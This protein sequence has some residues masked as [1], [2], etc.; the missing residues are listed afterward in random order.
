M[1]PNQSDAPQ[2]VYE[3][4][5][6]RFNEITNQYSQ[7]PMGWIMQAYDRASNNPWIQNRRVKQISSLP[8]EYSKDDVADAIRSPGEHELM[9]RQTHHALEATAYPMLKIRKVYTDIMTYR[10]YTSPHYITETDAK[11][12]MFQREM[13]LLDKFNQEMDPKATAHKMAGQALQEGK[14]FYAIRYSVDKAHNKVNYVFPQQL[15]SNWVKI[16]GFNNISGYTVS[17]NMFYFLQP[18]TDWRQYGDLLEPY[19]G[20]FKNV[21]EKVPS[22]VVYASHGSYRINLERFN[23]LKKNAQ[24]GLAGNPDPYMQNGRWAYWVT[25]PV[26]R[27]FVFEIDDTNPFA[28]SP[29]TGLYLSMQAIAQYEQVQLE[30]VQ[31]PLVSVM[32]GE[33]PYSNDNTSQQKDLYK[34]SNGGR[35]LFE[36]LWYQML[37]QNNTSGIGLYLAPAANLKLHQ[38]TEAPSATE[39]S[40]NGYAYT[41]EK[42]GLAGLIPISDNPRAGTVNISI[43]IE[44]RYCL[45]IYQQ[46]EKMMNYLYSRLNL[47]YEW[48]FHMFG[49]IYNDEKMR[50]EMQKS[51][52]LGL[53]PDLYVYNALMD[54]SLLDDMSMSAAVKASGIL[55]K[56]MPL[57]SSYTA[58]NGNPK[59]PPSPADD[60]GGRAQVDVSDMTS[61]GT[62]DFKDAE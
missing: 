10:Y 41:V 53:L 49:D 35:E 60:K 56:R 55:D 33:I 22:K 7:L 13:Q 18:G 38:L 3:K 4:V 20:D 45:R 36:Y 2:T 5:L 15:P 44:A 54:R 14:A 24:G 62:E 8:A 51:M 42:S 43:Q 61:E 21:V 59:L 30:L 52:T 47:K 27:V 50:A 29:M 34:L 6:A 26:D 11:D 16:I 12:P 46:F 31:N 37:A 32:T 39:I 57:I 28:C 40:T 25:L 17:F 48:R 1:L 58:K 9:L 19:I 23:K